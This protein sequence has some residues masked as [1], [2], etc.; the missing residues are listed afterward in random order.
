MIELEVAEHTTTA[1]FCAENWDPWHSGEFFFQYSF[2]K[3]TEE[4]K[5]NNAAYRFLTF[6]HNGKPVGA[7]VLSSFLLQLDLLAGDPAVL[8]M[9]KKLFPGLLQVPV[10]CCGLPV[11]F[12][13]HHFCV[14]DDAWFQEILT[15]VQKALEK[16]AAETN[17]KLLAWKEFSPEF[18]G[19]QD[20]QKLGFL[21]LNSLPDTE[22]F[23]KVEDP[24]KF[25]QMMRAPYRRKLKKTVASLQ[26]AGV[27][28]NDLKIMVQPF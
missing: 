20:L 5:V 2:L 13:Q 23:F 10:V 3:L 28:L 12:G 21:K 7:A 9:V 18:K 27:E 17:C 6:S 26:S 15:A 16:F 4:A 14:L 8:R 22:V 25:F 1:G 19:D 24:E 11:S